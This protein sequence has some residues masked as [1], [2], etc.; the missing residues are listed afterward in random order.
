MHEAL[1]LGRKL[2]KPLDQQGLSRASLK[3]M[4]ADVDTWKRVLKRL[5][6]FQGIVHEVA[7][8]LGECACGGLRSRGMCTTRRQIDGFGL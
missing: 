5:S 4:P 3:L 2:H 7:L 6:F 1:D 8:D